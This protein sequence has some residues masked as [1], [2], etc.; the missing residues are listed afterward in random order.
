MGEERGNVA[1][2]IG[3]L[4]ADSIAQE[5]IDILRAQLPEAQIDIRPGLKTEQ[6]KGIIGD[7]TALIVR[8]ENGRQFTYRQYCCSRR[9]YH[10]H[11]NGIGSTHSSRQ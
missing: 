11:A 6:L 7:Y 3:I 10:R 2:E 1:E 9:T 8:S 5:G 4:I